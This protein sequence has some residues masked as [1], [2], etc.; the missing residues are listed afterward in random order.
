MNVRLASVLFN[1][2]RLQRSMR[3]REM[4]MEM[5]MEHK[6]SRAIFT[7]CKVLILLQLCPLGKD[8]FS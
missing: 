3:K 6:P 4:E 1:G 5:E 2:G 7:D 8:D